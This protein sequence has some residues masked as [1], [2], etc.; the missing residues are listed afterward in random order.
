MLKLLGEDNP[1]LPIVRIDF[2]AA[3]E[4]RLSLQN[5]L[6]HRQGQRRLQEQELRREAARSSCSCRR[7]CP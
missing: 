7:R 6:D 1:R 3:K 4:L 2:Y 5:A